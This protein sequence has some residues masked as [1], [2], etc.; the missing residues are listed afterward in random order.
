[1]H[2]TL[3]NRLMLG[4]VVSYIVYIAMTAG[5]AALLAGDATVTVGH[6]RQSLI[7]SIFAGMFAFIGSFLVFR[8]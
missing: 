5:A 1:M 6:L 3:P 8:D 2:V 4:L 7:I